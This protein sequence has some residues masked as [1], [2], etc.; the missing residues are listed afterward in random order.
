MEY[1]EQTTTRKTGTDSYIDSR[2]TASWGGKVRGGGIE[3]KGKRTQVQGQ[4]CGDEGGEGNVRGLN[5][6]GKN[7]VKMFLKVCGY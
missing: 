1:N 6:N 2:L 4:R 3:Q 7:T 5:S